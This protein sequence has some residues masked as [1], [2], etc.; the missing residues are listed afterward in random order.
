MKPANFNTL[1][2]DIRD[3]CATV[4]ATLLGAAK[5]IATL[6]WPALLVCA[7]FLALAITLIPV[8]LTLFVLF[9]AIKLAVGLIVVDKQR[10]R[11]N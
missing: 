10:S 3:A 11:R 1:L 7:F 4:F 2:D 5:Q 6:P 8:A 9:L